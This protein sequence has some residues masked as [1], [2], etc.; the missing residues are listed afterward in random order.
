[1][2]LLPAVNLG[3]TTVQQYVFIMEMLTRA[4]YSHPHNIFL[5]KG[6]Y[7]KLGS[8]FILSVSMQGPDNLNLQ[9]AILFVRE[10]RQHNE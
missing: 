7:L 2:N 10:S 4:K 1:M 3:I 6:I 5:F 8:K 9:H